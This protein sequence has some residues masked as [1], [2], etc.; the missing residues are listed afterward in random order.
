VKLS[1]DQEAC[2]KKEL[3]RLTLA[4]L[5]SAATIVVG[6]W[7]VASAHEG[8]KRK[9]APASA[10]KLKNPLAATEENVA[11]GRSLFSR[12]CAVCHGEDGKAK[13]E[14]AAAMRVKPTDLTGKAMH[15]ITDGEIYWVVTSGI[16]KSGMPAF[17][18]KASDT[19]RWQMALFVKHLM[20][21]H[22]HSAD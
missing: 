1:N 17:K 9:N 10:K 2:M 13:T 8:H 5:L 21:E 4:L 3:T 7:P 22:P 16:Q 12:H 18:A 6:R 20:G 15:G 11:G 19:E 14:A